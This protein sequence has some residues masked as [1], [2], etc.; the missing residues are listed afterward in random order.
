MPNLPKKEE[1]F[2]NE[3]APDG[4]S[5]YFVEGQPGPK[6]SSVIC[7]YDIQTKKRKRIHH[8]PGWATIFLSPNGKW[9][10]FVGRGDPNRELKVIPAN[11]GEER[12]LYRFTQ[13][14][15]G[16]VF[17]C[18]TPDSQDI[19]FFQEKTA[20]NPEEALCRIPVTG[21]DVEELGVLSINA[22]EYLNIHPNG[23]QIVFSSTGPSINYPEYWVMENFLPKK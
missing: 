15:G 9:L 7:S 14:G 18:W 16:P 1:Y 8:T 4:K 21:S 23:H 10:A 12:M 22:P 19:L 20:K 3:W 17:L 6:S 13:S 2:F 11:G 5:L